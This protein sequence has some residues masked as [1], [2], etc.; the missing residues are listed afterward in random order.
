MGNDVSI[1]SASYKDQ[2]GAATQINSPATAKWIIPLVLLMCIFSGMLKVILI[3][4]NYSSI[5]VQS[6]V[7]SQLKPPFCVPVIDTQRAPV[8]ETNS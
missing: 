6:F 7:K 1:M 4:I 8:G 2:M 5:L 3:I